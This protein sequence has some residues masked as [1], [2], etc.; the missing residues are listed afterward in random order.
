VPSR[1]VLF[2]DEVAHRLRAPFDLLQPLRHPREALRGARD[3]TRGILEAAQLGW[4]GVSDTIFNPDKIGPHRRF[5]WATMPLVDLKDVKN[6]LG[7]TVNDVVLATA[8]GALGGFMRAHRDATDG[9]EFRA[10]VPVSIRSETETRKLGNRVAMMMAE[11]P[12]GEPDPVTRLARVIETTR[13]L[14]GSSQAQG[15]AWLEDFADRVGGEFFLEIIRRATRARPF[16]VAVTNV[17]GPQFPLYMLGAR[18]RSI[19]PMV[20]LFA[21]QALGIAVMS[22]DGQVYWGFNSDWD[23]LPD[24]H[25]LVVGL[26]V[27]FEAFRKAAARAAPVDA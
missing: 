21:N 24:L 13:R 26:G 1:A 27:E 22:Y 23:S 17:P 8:A 3:V 10:L 12:V 19:Y 11:L 14:K 4:K 2:V 6:R 15:V 7:G 9:V 18:L 5:D 25:D 20:P 16:N